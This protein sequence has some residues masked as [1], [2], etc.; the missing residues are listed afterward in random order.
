MAQ[1]PTV[2]LVPGQV[3]HSELIKAMAGDQLVREFILTDLE[4]T[5][6]YAEWYRRLNLAE[7]ENR[8][9]V[10]NEDIRAGKILVDPSRAK[11]ESVAYKTIQNSR[12]IQ[13]NAKYPL[14]KSLNNEEFASVQNRVFN[15]V[16]E[17]MPA[18]LAGGCAAGYHACHAAGGN[19]N[20][21]V[22]GYYACIAAD[23]DKW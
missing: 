14:L 22:A 16:T 5:T 19:E 7:R 11:G 23:P 17:G 10:V 2:T 21:C 4:F 15:A 6:H 13:M 20:G 1:L 8:N 3:V 12:I 18:F 9:K